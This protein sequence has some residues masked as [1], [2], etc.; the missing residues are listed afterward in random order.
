MIPTIIKKCWHTTGSKGPS[1]GKEKPLSEFYK[2][3]KLKEGYCYQCKECWKIRHNKY[4]RTPAGKSSQQMSRSKIMSDP[5]K[6]TNAVKVLRNYRNTVHGKRVRKRERL[7]KNFGVTLEQYDLMAQQQNKLC[8]ICGIHQSKLTRALAI[9]HDHHTG[10]I[11]GL[12]CGRCNIGLGYFKDSKENLLNA[13]TYL[14][15][16]L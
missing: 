8:A 11:R 1:C 9:D 4:L 3:S 5:D 7:H 15:K 2:D 6:H 14:D 10:K 16:A 13:I 12:L